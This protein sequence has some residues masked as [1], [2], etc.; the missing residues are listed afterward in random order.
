MHTI[1]PTTTDGVPPTGWRKSS[2]SGGNQGE[3]LEVADGHATVPVRDSKAPAGPALM[4]SPQGWTRFVT[5]V[6]HGEL[7]A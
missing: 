4:F 6:K 5:A 1:E 3:C 7:S 2:Y